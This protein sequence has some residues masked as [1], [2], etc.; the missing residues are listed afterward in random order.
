MLYELT[1]YLF[2]SV[3]L[4]GL[5][6]GISWVIYPDRTQNFVYRTSWEVT[7]NALILKDTVKKIYNETKKNIIIEKSQEKK[8]HG[9]K[10]MIINEK[11]NHIITP[12]Y[13]FEQLSSHK[14][15]LKNKTKKIIYI[16]KKINDKE[17]WKQIDIKYFWDV[18]KSKQ[19]EYLNDVEIIE[20]PFIQILLHNGNNSI[21]INE[22]LKFFY[23]NGN[24]ILDI[25]FLKWYLYYYYNIELDTDYK[26]DI[27]DSNIKLHILKRYD[28]VSL[29]NNTYEIVSDAC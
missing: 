26:L 29:A 27:I 23:V 11:T 1:Y 15:N 8:E 18:T 17:Y 19:L 9:W 4:G 6:L 20:N 2:S 10:M 28:S 12:K 25:V 14:I 13:N 3:C 7:K 24:Q 22:H 16:S 5:C 21:D